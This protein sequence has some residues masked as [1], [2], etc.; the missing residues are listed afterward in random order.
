MIICTH[1]LETES[2]Y[3]YMNCT[4]TKYKFET[5]YLVQFSQMSRDCH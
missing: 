5:K 1:Y 4:E 2:L 3:F